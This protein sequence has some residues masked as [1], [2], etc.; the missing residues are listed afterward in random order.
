MINDFT[1]SNI[2]NFEQHEWTI[3]QNNKCKKI[4][5][6]AHPDDES[7]WASDILDN[8]THVV[9]LFGQSKVSDNVTKCRLAEFESVMSITNSS[10][11][12]FRFPEK[13]RHMFR[14]NKTII[15]NKIFEL[16]RSVPNVGEIYTHNSYGEYGHYD[17]IMCNDM[18]KH[19]Y[20]LYYKNN[21]VKPALYEFYPHLN[22]NCEGDDR[23]KNIE[24]VVE[25]DKHKLL[26]DQYK[27]QTVDLFR[28][29]RF[30]FRKI[31]F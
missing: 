30:E 11:N 17:H 3:V 21:I 5:F 24:Y 20:S 13:N 1:N 7:I 16:L 8:D 9:V 6:V 25:N 26:L 10:W 29:L 18:V 14:K 4:V 19:C 2:L 28:N 27:S 31:Q 12:Y 23:F 22:Y 15:I